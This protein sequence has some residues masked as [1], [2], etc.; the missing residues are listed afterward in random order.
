MLFCSLF[1]HVSLLQ[2]CYCIVLGHEWQ[3]VKINIE[4]ITLIDTFG[5]RRY[6]SVADYFKASPNLKFWPKSR[7]HSVIT[8]KENLIID[9]EYED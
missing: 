5:G 1:I 8:I 2:I 9:D 4:H 7:R 6:P 3:F